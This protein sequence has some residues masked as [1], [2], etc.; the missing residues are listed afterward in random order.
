MK[1]NRRVSYV[2]LCVV[3]LL[4][5]PIIGLRVFRVPGLYQAMG[6]A[7]FAAMVIASWILGA[8]VLVAGTEEK[9]RMALAGMLLVLPFTLMALLWV[10]IAPPWEATPVENR[11]RYLVLLLA[12][13][14]V[15]AGFVVFERALREAG[16]R[17]YSTLGNTLG[18]LAGAAYLVWNC[19]FLGLYVAKARGGQAPAA[20]VSLSDSLDAIIF[21][22]CILTYLATLIFAVCMGQVGW[23]GRGATRSYVIANLL[24]L[25]LIMIKGLSYPDPT[26]TSAPWYFNL[27]FIAGIPAVPWIMP[28]LL[29]VVLLRQAGREET[30]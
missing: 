22:A 23:L 2:F 26:A 8:R 13:V 28:Y 3:P 14:A 1:T 24:L 9:R 6:G 11:M 30:A 21:I 4:N 17:L 27:A 19:F 7:Y 25:I 5:F 29:G 18:I 10:G 16:E 20:L 12:S 15:T